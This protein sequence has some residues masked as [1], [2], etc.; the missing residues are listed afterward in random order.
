MG[1]KSTKV[2]DFIIELSNLVHFRKEFVFYTDFISKLEYENLIQ[3]E[4]IDYNSQRT[5]IR[6]PCDVSLKALTQFDN[7]I[8][9]IIGIVIP[10]QNE[11]LFYIKNLIRKKVTKFL[12]IIISSNTVSIEIEGINIKQ[13]DLTLEQGILQKISQDTEKSIIKMKRVLSDKIKSRKLDN[14]LILTLLD[15][16]VEKNELKKNIFNK[17]IQNFYSGSKRAFFILSR[18]NL[19]NNLEM[20]ATIGNNTLLKTIDYY[21]TPLDG[22]ISAPLNRIISFIHKEWG[23]DFSHLIE[24]GSNAKKV[25]VGDK[26]QSMWG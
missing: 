20:S 14:D 1:D 10:K 7:F 19:L 2:E 16:E 6:C 21:Q 5:H 26:I 3:N 8:S 15:F 18:L 4:D 17:E 12:T 11:N 13:I 9:W 23:V 22:I 24:N 25:D